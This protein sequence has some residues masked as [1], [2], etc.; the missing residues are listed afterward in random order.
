MTPGKQAWLGVAVI[1]LAFLAAEVV[2]EQLATDPAGQGMVAGVFA[3]VGVL[4][5]IKLLISAGVRRS[6]TRKKL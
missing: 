4:I 3:I 2:A 1:I 6:R 5:G